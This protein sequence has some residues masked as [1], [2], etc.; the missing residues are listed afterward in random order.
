MPSLLLQSCSTWELERCDCM[1]LVD[2]I[3]RG[4]S[5]IRELHRMGGGSA[6]EQQH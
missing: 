3:V 4:I 5:D 1:Q 6:G 2:I